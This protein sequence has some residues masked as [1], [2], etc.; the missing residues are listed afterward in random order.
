M[1]N[2][3][4]NMVSFLATSL[5]KKAGEIIAGGISAWIWTSIVPSA[6]KGCRVAGA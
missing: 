2:T 1:L 5:L 4:L 3:F 6:A